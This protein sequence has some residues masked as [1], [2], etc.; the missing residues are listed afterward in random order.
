MVFK[1]LLPQNPDP[2]MD[3]DEAYTYSFRR[4]VDGLEAPV[5]SLDE[6]IRNERRET[7]KYYK[8]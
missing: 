6:N 3:F 8:H 4:R 5:G 1:P 2:T 7:K